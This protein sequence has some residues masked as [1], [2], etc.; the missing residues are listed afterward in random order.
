[1]DHFGIGNAMRALAHAYIQTAR[2]SGRTTRLLDSLKDGD[3]VVCATPR[4]A[5]VLTKKCRE[6]GLKVDCIS[7]PPGEIHR[8]LDRKKSE[9]RTVFEHTWV[10]QFH[11]YQIER[12]AAEIDGFEDVLSTWDG[13][14]KDPR[15]K[16]FRADW[17]G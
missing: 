4:E 12:T 15:P 1:M 8:L 2:Q 16:P 14:G 7:V 10:E 5:E 6:R 3:R 11:L 9:R 17:R 13:I